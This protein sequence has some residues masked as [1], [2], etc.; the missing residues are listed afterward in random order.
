MPKRANSRLLTIAW[1]VTDA[2]DFS[3]FESVRVT[4]DQAAGGSNPSQRARP[5]C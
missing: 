4:T 3:G 2:L 5:T 1:I